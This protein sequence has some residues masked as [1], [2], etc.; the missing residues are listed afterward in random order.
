MRKISFVCLLALLA[1]VGGVYAGWT[2][3]QGG[4]K[5]SEEVKKSA[6]NGV[7]YNTEKGTINVDTTGVNLLIDDLNNDYNADLVINK[8]VVITFTP[9]PGADQNVVDNGINLTVTFTEDFGSYNGV[10]ILTC[11]DLIIGSLDRTE[12]LK[13]TK[14][15]NKFICELDLSEYIKLGNISLPTLD[16]YKEFESIILNKMITITVSEKK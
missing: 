5:S 13:L 6:L 2:Y 7:I 16:S 4:V 9:T 3:S 1:T 8:K 11:T 10:D 12:G 14:I 15:D